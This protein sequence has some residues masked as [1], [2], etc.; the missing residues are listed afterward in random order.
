MNL[1]TPKDYMF[2]TRYFNEWRER[3]SPQS[4]VIELCPDSR[5]ARIHAVLLSLVSIWS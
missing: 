4:L 5:L 2:L 3:D 1:Q